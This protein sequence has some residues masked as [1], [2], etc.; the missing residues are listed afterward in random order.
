MTKLLESYAGEQ[1]TLDTIISARAALVDF[2][3]ATLKYSIALKSGDKNY[4]MPMEEMNEARSSVIKLNQMCENKS[5]PPV[6]TGDVNEITDLFAYAEKV[7]KEIVDK[8]GN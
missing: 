7:I 1:E 8:M 2:Y 5:L 4:T 3:K 6:F